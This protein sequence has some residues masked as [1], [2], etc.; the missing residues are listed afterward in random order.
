MLKTWTKQ[1]A[2]EAGHML[3]PSD[4]TLLR[5]RDATVMPRRDL[6]L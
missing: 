2:A 3:I 5:D 1:S 6:G 4:A